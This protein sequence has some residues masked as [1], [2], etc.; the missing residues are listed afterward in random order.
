MGDVNLEVPD[1]TKLM[2]GIP[3]DDYVVVSDDSTSV[4]AHGPIFEEV[5]EK[6]PKGFVIRNTRLPLVLA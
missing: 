6:A 3:P 4:L 1:F 5:I 2:E